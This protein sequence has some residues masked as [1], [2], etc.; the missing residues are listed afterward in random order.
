MPSRNPVLS[1]SRRRLVSLAAALLAGPA[2][3]AFAAGR[4]LRGQVSYR[5]RIALPPEAVLEVR[6]VD[7]SLADAPARGIAVTRVKTRHRLPIPYRLRFDDAKIQRGHTYALEARITVNGRPWFVTATR[8]AVLTGGPDQTDIHVELVKSAG[9]TILAAAGR[10]RAEAIRNRGVPPDFEAVLDIAADGKV[11][12]S[13]GCNRISGKA[14]VEG[15][16]MSFGPIISTK[17]ACAPDIMDQEGHFLA[18]LADTRL[19]RIDET[20]DKLILVD[21]KGITVLRLAKL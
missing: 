2:T 20:R 17:M 12:G 19:W 11:T 3:R 10:W 14:T 16:H 5:E 7:V 6:L 21:A 9:A 4:A 13:G 1:L 8:H 18:A 15:A